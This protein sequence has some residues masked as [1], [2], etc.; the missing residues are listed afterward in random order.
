MKNVYDKGASA[1]GDVHYRFSKGA[2]ANRTGRD[3]VGR[4]GGCG[5]RAWGG[6]TDE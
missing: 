5:G 4:R 2:L 6:V 3:C 1:G